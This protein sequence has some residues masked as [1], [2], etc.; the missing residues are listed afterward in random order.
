[1]LH[2]ESNNIK[3]TIEYSSFDTF[4]RKTLSSLYHPICHAEKA[5]LNVQ[6][7]IN[8]PAVNLKVKVLK[9]F[10]FSICREHT[11]VTGIYEGNTIIAYHTLHYGSN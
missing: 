7:N 4:I 3:Q 2:A 9:C 5:E 6:L 11:T 8:E 10:I 1:M